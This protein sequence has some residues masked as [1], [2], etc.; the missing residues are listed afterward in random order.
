MT[1][2]GDDVVV[3]PVRRDDL[4]GLV[5]LAEGAGAGLTTLPAS[6]QAL[7]LRI[8]R[9]L[10]AFSGR[11]EE[12]EGDCYLM[13][14][15]DVAT[16]AVVG[17]SGIF[18]GVGL[19]KAFYSYRILTLTRTSADLGVRVDTR[20][21][22][23]VNDYA[24]ATE[25]GTLYLAPGYR[26][27][28][29]GALLAR[30]RYLMMAGFPGRFSELVLAEIRGWQDPGGR[31]PFWEAVG[32]H[33]FRMS[34]EEADQ[35]SGLGNSRFIADLLPGHPIY[36]DL[37]PKEARDAIGRPH[38]AA[39]PA[40]RLLEREGFR[41]GR[42][43]DVFDAG[44]V[45]DVR[46]DDIRTVRGSREV[47]I[48]GVAPLRDGFAPHLAAT[49][50]MEGFRVVRAAVGVRADGRIDVEEGAARRLGVGSGDRVRIVA[51]ENGG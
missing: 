19:G 40:L 38:E 37:L 11:S 6:G 39:R 7:G 9:S 15:E 18:A 22:Q 5:R 30:C 23:L 17:T 25:V 43:V 10:A 29:N 8:E 36:V 42:A 51:Q 26:R 48:A 13:V 24:G 1:A 3:R 27:H 2:P 20:I 47:E 32:R 35:L 49:V 14:L 4:A 34:F 44:P 41:F 33:F 31:W 46:R 21:L 28:G 50:D 16:G 45:V 12:A